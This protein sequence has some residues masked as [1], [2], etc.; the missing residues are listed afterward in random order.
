MLIVVFSMGTSMNIIYIII[1]MQ[2]CIPRSS[3]FHYLL[4][5]YKWQLKYKMVTCR[6]AMPV[7][8]RV[9]M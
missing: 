6:L 4:E 3:T 7:A 5:P 2:A 9:A 8:K 1:A